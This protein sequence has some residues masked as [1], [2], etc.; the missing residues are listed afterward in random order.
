MSVND[1]SSRPAVHAPQKQLDQ[2]ETLLPSCMNINLGK[3]GSHSALM[4][5]MAFNA[6]QSRLALGLA[7]ITERL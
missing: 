4:H 7:L 1:A 2:I 6:D 3:P 5:D